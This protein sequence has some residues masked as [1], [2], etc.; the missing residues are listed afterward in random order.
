MV[1]IDQ[2]TMTAGCS[3][4]HCW[5]AISQLNKLAFPVN[6][7]FHWVLLAPDIMQALAN[8]ILCRLGHT[9]EKLNLMKKDFLLY[10]LKATYNALRYAIYNMNEPFQKTKH[11]KYSLAPPNTPGHI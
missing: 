1:W 11:L 5:H 4:A 3:Q 10:R 2:T 8:D 7:C 6:S 9:C